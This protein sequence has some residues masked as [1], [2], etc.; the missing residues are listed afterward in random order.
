MRLLIRNDKEKIMENIWN[1]FCKISL[2]VLIIIFLNSILGDITFRLQYAFPKVKETTSEL[3]KTSVEPL[4]VSENSTKMIAHR[5]EKGK[6]ALEPQA[7]YSISGYVVAKNNNFWFRDIMR[8][9]FDDLCLMDIGLVWGDLADEQTLKQ[10]FKFNS[11]KS[12]DSARTL[13]WRY[14]FGTPFTNDYIK[15]H[16]SHTHLIPSTVNI[17]SAL[18]TI[19]K[20]D[21]IKLDGYLVDI[22]T[23]KGEIVAKTSLSRFDNNPTSRGYGACEDMYV[24]KVQ[25]GDKIYK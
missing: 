9:K 8:S 16:I 10:Y 14:K 25:I 15:S 12:L 2:I 23:D 4:Q 20:N 1:W 6:Y 5:G 21:T 22:Y 13:Y 19:K 17:M 18:L 11:K 3:I 7:S 24:T